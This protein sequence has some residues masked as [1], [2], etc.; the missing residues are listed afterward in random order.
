MHFEIVMEEDV[1]EFPEF[2]QAIGDAYLEK[3]MYFEALDLYM[4]LAESEEVS[5]S[6]PFL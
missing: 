5:L 1:E 4:D 2:F 6:F 3:K